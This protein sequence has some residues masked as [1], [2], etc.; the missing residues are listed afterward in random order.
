VL[1]G[2]IFLPMICIFIG[3]GLGFIIRSLI[4]KKGL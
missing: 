1:L 2:P 4:I 3:L